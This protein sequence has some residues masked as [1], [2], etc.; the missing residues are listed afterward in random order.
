MLKVSSLRFAAA[1]PQ[2]LLAT[3]LLAAAALSACSGGNGPGASDPITTIPTTPAPTPV[4]DTT[5]VTVKLI[6]FNDFHGYTDPPT[7]NTTAADPADGSKTVGVPTGGSAYLATMVKKLK[8]QNPL[9]ITVA[10]GDLIG[11]S[12]LDSALFH[13][14][15]AVLTLN[16]MGLDFSSVGN[17]EF[18]KGSTELKRIQNGGCFPGGTIGSDTC[19]ENGSFPGAKYQ[20]LAANVVNL[21]TGKPL[22]PAYAI[23]QLDIGG[24]K[25]LGVAF[26]GLVLKGTPNIVT[27]DGVAGLAFA[28]EAGTANSLIPEIKAQ[29]VNTIVVLIHEGASTTGIYNNASCPGVSGDILPIVDKLDPAIDLVVSGHTH[30]AYLCKRNGRTL[31]SAGFYG[32]LVTDIDLTIDRA[33]ADVT[34]VT[35]NNRLVVNDVTTPARADVAAAYPAQARDA[36]VQAIVKKYDDVAAPLANRV[37]GSVT[38]AISRSNNSAG[39]SALGDVIA[40][41][42]LLATKP[43]NL[44]AAVIAFMNPGGIRAD[45]SFPSSSVGEGDGKVTYNEAFTVQPF[46]NTL[47]T[48]S[49][50][51]AQMKTLLEQQF[52]NPSAGQM[53]ILQISNGFTYTWDNSQP[54]GSKVMASSMQLNGV[55]IDPNTQYKVTVNSFLATGGDNFVLL[56]D[57]TNRLGGALDIDA[58]EAYFKAN[59][60]GVAPGPANRITRLN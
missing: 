28:D 7:G 9:N 4:V 54:T 35:A 48:M 60:S 49:I 56:K 5:P 40:D 2:T 11:A 39:E 10:A 15:P 51:G 3:S 43:G 59:S 30:Q 57:G 47:T 22:F 36:D 23:K 37:I 20:Y 21:S 32:R 24:G 45:I 14:E 29:G 17:H 38:A 53:R 58:L 25:K 18:D 50:S 16:S 34:A 8:A 31:T 42:Q 12:P 52:D 44:G 13:D 46:Y 19:L 55:T 26:I 27:P 33:T 6:A 1:L 41:A